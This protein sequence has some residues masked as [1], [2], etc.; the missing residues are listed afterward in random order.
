M[1]PTQDSPGTVRTQ[2]R[3]HLDVAVVGPFVAVHALHCGGLP[4]HQVDP[5]QRLESHGVIDVGVMGRQVHPPDDEQTIHLQ[6]EM[7][8]GPQA[9]PRPE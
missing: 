2:S 3:T 4:L 5:E 1:E 8:K 9:T 6:E 7:G